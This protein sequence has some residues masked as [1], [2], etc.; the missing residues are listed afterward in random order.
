MKKALLSFVLALGFASSGCL[1]PDHLYHSLK[2][3]NAD[4][5]DQDWVN[6]VVFLPMHVFVYPIAIVGDV[7]IFNTIGYWSGNYLIKDPGAFPGFQ[8][9]AK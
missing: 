9:E 8:R 5:S 1:G 2:N 7:L 4:L 6:E 3:W